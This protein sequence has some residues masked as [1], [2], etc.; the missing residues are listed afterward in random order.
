MSSVTELH[1]ISPDLGRRLIGEK[2][3][4]RGNEDLSF[5]SWR[6]ILLVWYWLWEGNSNTS[7]LP[8]LVAEFTEISRL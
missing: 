8:V 5:P 6:F 3:W 7:R 4:G 2:M 1:E